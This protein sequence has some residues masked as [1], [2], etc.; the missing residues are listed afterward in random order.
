VPAERAA[1][2]ISLAWTPPQIESSQELPHR[3]TGTKLPS[4][5]TRTRISCTLLRRVMSMYSGATGLKKRRTTNRSVFLLAAFAMENLLKAFLI[6]ENPK[7]IEGGRLSKRLLNGHGL[8]KLQQQCKRVPSP[9]RTRHVLQTL[10]VG[11]NSWA[12]YPCSN[13]CR[14]RVGRESGDARILGCL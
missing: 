2:L 14:S 8:S 6:H 4:L 12:R 11:V 7:Y 5:C 9:K 1:T 13:V 3:S 10:E